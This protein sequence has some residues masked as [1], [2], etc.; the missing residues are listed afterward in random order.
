MACTYFLEDDVL[1]LWHGE[2][3]SSIKSI[4][5]YR[6]NAAVRFWVKRLKRGSRRKIPWKAEIDGYFKNL[7]IRR[8]DIRLR[9]SCFFSYLSWEGKKNY[10]PHL[11][12][13][14]GHSDDFVL[15]LRAMDEGERV[16][17]VSVR[18]A[19]VLFCFLQWPLQYLFIDVA[20]QLWSHMN[21]IQFHE[22]LHYIV[23][24]TIGFEDFDYAGLLKEFWHPSPASYKRKIKKNKKLFK[25]IEMT[26]NYDGKNASLSLP[27]TLQESLTEHVR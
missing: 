1:A 18:P 27:G 4:P 5:R 23:S 8:S 2:E 20:K 17:T 11:R 15:C 12:L 10:L 25:M 14:E 3:A 7:R 9:I 26:L 16:E 19:T 21:V 24:Y 22:T 13:Y 6:S